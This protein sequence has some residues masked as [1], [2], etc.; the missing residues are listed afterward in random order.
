MGFVTSPHPTIRSLGSISPP[1]Y[2]IELET[3][4]VSGADGPGLLDSLS[5]ELFELLE[6]DDDELESVEVLEQDDEDTRL[7]VKTFLKLQLVIP[8]ELM[9]QQVIPS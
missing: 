9:L 8:P 3:T 2:R 7:G 4:W 6:L 5:D 1:I